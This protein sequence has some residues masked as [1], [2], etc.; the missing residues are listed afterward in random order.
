MQFAG[1]GSSSGS[2]HELGSKLSSNEK[3]RS[4]QWALLPMGRRHWSTQLSGMTN[5]TSTSSFVTA[6]DD[7][8]PTTVVVVNDAAAAASPAVPS[9]PDEA[10][11]TSLGGTDGRGTGASVHEYLRKSLEIV[12]ASSMK[13]S[14]LAQVVVPEV[15]EGPRE[16]PPPEGE[17]ADNDGG[18]P[19]GGDAGSLADKTS[20]MSGHT[21]P[22]ADESSVASGQFGGHAG[23]VTDESSVMSHHSSAEKNTV[24]GHHSFFAEKNMVT[25]HHSFENEAARMQ[26]EQ[27]YDDMEVAPPS[28]AASFASVQEAVA[29]AMDPPSRREPRLG[30]FDPECSARQTLLASIV[31][32]RGEQ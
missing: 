11:T 17:K 5:M 21:E 30:L 7:A 2:D 28:I 18:E 26:V 19:A 20:V 4:S 29:T 10:E 31:Q 27:Q 25:S 15:E 12:A 9:S 22:L 1:S 3:R 14:A 32:G 6:F 24:S 8:T 23:P 13:A 16:Q